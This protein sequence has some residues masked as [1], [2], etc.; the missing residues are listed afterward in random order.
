M[1]GAGLWPRIKDFQ[2]QLKSKNVFADL[3]SIV[4]VAD[5]IRRAV[6]WQWY[7]EA[8]EQT[9]QA[10]YNMECLF[11]V[12]DHDGRTGIFHLFNSDLY[13]VPQYCCIGTGAAVAKYLLSWIYSPTLPIDL[14][15]RIA[16]HIFKAAKDHGDGCG[17]DTN[18]FPLFQGFDKED[19]LP[20]Y[21]V[22]ETDFLGGMFRA[23]K[24]LIVGC[25]N[26]T[27]PDNIF[28]AHITDFSRRMHLL[29]TGS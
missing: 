26:K 6:Q 13:P 18:L 22:E 24:P 2:D 17:G 19:E 16:L 21:T 11:S 14:F 10:G 5:A 3:F 28:D 15:A 8:V 4:D 23:L 27:M 12:K 1:T 25:V 7:K 29:R 9:N 20:H